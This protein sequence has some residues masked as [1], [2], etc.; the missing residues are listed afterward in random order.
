MDTMPGTLIRWHALKGILRSSLRGSGHL[1]DIGGNDGFISSAAAAGHPLLSPVLVDIDMA[2][3]RAARARGRRAVCASALSLPSTDGSIDAVLCLDMIEHV[4]D[5]RPIMREIA[6][7][8]KAGG[9]AVLTAPAGRGISFPGMGSDEATRL[10]ERWGHIRPGF[11]RGHLVRICEEHGLRVTRTGR[12]L[13]LLSRAAYQFLVLHGPMTP[14]K[15]RL[16]RAIAPLESV[17]K[18]KA[19]ELIVVAVKR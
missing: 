6:R 8:L 12:Y 9:T 2:G 17:L 16:F 13:N 5:E 18:W 11:S 3:L 1:L 7:V 10:Q 14:A 15:R 4:K 19:Q